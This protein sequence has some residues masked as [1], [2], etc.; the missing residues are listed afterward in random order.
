MITLLHIHPHI[1]KVVFVSYHQKPFNLT[2]DKRKWDH[3]LKINIEFGVSF[4]VH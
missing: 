3:L 2:D 1:Q 4:P